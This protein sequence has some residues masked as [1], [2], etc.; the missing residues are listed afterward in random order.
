MLV[1]DM[2]AMLIFVD[3][4]IYVRIKIDVNSKQVHPI[5]FDLLVKSKEQKK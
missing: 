5:Y 3:I 4:M 1:V 2:F